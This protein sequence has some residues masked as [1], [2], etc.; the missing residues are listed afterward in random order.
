V[1]LGVAAELPRFE[2]RG[3]RLGH[4]HRRTVL[5]EALCVL[6]YVS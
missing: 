2:Q 1:A 3:V 6:S 5:D 4:W